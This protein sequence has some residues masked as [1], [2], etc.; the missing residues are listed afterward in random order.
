MLQ[1]FKNKVYML[2]SENDQLKLDLHNLEQNYL[3]VNY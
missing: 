1:L 3:G 2:K